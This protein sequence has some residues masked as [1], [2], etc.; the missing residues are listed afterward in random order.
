[1]KFPDFVIIGAMKCGTTALWRNLA[2]H[3]GIFMG[4]N[5]DDPKKTSTEIRF[6]NNDGPHH[7]WRRGIK[8]YKSLFSGKCAGEKCAN[9]IESPTA[10]SRMYSY[11]PDCKLILCVREPVDRMLSEFWMHHFKPEKIDKF[12]AFS[13]G[14]GPRMRSRYLDQLRRSVLPYYPASQV[15]VVVQERMATDTQREMNRLFAWL[16]VPEVYADVKRLDFVD[17]DRDFTSFRVWETDH[18][19]DM[20]PDLRNELRDYFG[21]MRVSYSTGWATIFRSG[22]I[23]QMEDED[24]S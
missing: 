15:Y 8:W 2:Q 10:I 23:V 13:R 5:P 14:S 22:G 21:F 3:P 4:R 1:M 18:K 17:R 19:V 9:Y 7:T 6:W 16:D 11:M 12:E 24:K 20:D